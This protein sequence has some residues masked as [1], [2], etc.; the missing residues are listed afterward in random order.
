MHP[1]VLEGLRGGLGQIPVAAG[2]QRPGHADLADL[3]LG[4]RLSVLAQQ[5]HPGEQ[6]GPAARC[7]PLVVVVALGQIGDHHRGLG[8]AVVLREDRAEPV[9]GLLEPHG[10]HRRGAVVHGLQR[11]QVAGV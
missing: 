2:Q 3:A 10:I 6:G 9:D 1:A 5:R 11:R 7:Q 4:H 8:L